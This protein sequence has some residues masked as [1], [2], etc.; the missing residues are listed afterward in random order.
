MNYNYNGFNGYGWQ[1][2][3]LQEQ[4]RQYIQQNQPQ[5]AADERIWVNGEAQARDYLIAPNGFARLWD[6]QGSVFYEKRADASGRPVLETFEYHKIDNATKPKQAD[7]GSVD[8]K[9][10]KE[11]E[12][13]KKRISALEKKG[14]KSDE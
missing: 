8:E 12:S 5:M 13:L 6:S 11:L 1:Q 2:P 7:F 4:Q 14:G 9:L 3:Q 10:I